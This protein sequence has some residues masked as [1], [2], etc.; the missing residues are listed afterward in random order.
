[1]FQLD[2]S[3]GGHH[4]IQ[5]T[6]R[7]GPQLSGQRVPPQLLSGSGPLWPWVAGSHRPASESCLWRQIQERKSCLGPRLWPA[8]TRR[9]EVHFLSR[10]QLPAA[11]EEQ[12]Q[13]RFCFWAGDTSRCH[14]PLRPRVRGSPS[15][16][17]VPQFCKAL[18]SC[19]LKGSVPAGSLAP[20]R[21]P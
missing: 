10:E 4:S 5:H 15:L 17:A 7:A 9:R 18:S 2:M 8:H 14:F 12:A 1:M 11:H 3:S 21:P 20:S 19:G 6:S 16:P 13:T